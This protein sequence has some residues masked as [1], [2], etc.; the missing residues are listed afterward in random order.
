V[1]FDASRSMIDYLTRGVHCVI[2][3]IVQDLHG[4]W[5][6]PGGV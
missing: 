4:C 6:Y 3:G 5:L 2:S 1:R